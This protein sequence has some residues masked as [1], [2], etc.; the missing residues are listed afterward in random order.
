MSTQAKLKKS[1]EHSKIPLSLK[2]TYTS[3]VPP[4]GFDLATATPAELD[5]YGFPRVNPQGSREF[6]TLRA[7]I[8]RGWTPK[9]RILP[10]LSV[11]KRRGS[12]HRIPDRGGVPNLQSH[13]A[14]CVVTANQRLP[15]PLSPI[16]GHTTDF[17]HEQQVN[18]IGADNH[19][20][21]VFFKDFWKL[22]DLTAF[23]VSTGAPDADPDSALSSY[24]TTNDQ[25]Q[26]VNY[27]SKDGYV[28]ELVFDGT[29]THQ[30]LTV[31]SLEKSTA[32]SG[33]KLVGYQSTINNQQHVIF[34]DENNHIHELV[35]DSS[36]WTD[37][38]LMNSGFPI[39]D[40]KTPL[41]AYYTAWNEQQHII[42]ATL[43]GDVHEL[44]YASGWK[45]HDLM[46]DISPA[47]EA[48]NR[49]TFLDAFGTDFN[50][51]Q[52]INY[53]GADGHIHELF[54]DGSWQAKDLSKEAGALTPFLLPILTS[55]L[56]GYSTEYDDRQH[57]HYI[58]SD[59]HVHEL[60]FDG[61]WQH[62][63]LTK[64]SKCPV[65]ANTASVLNGYATNFNS[66]QHVNFLGTD[67]HLWEIAFAGGNWIST[68]LT[69]FALAPW[70]NVGAIWTVPAAKASLQPSGTEAGGS[71][72]ISSMWVGIDGN[73]DSQDVLQIGT[74]QDVD[75]Q[76]NPYYFAWYEWFAPKRNSDSPAYVDPIVINNVPVAPG[77]EFLASVGYIE[78]NTR[79]RL[80][81]ANISTGDYFTIDLDPPPYAVFNGLFVEWIVEAPGSGEP[82]ETL[83]Q[84][85]TAE[86][87]SAGGMNDEG[88]VA[89]PKNGVKQI[90]QRGDSTLVSVTLASNDV[91]I[92]SLLWDDS[93]ITAAAAAPVADT[94][95][96]LDSYYTPFKEQVHV[97]YLSKD[98]VTGTNH[99]FEIF[100]QNGAVWIVNNLTDL[101]D[102]PPPKDASPLD[103]YSTEFNQQQH[104]NYVADDGNIYE[105]F[106]DGGWN[107]NPIMALA[108][109]AGVVASPDKNTPLCGYSTEFDEQQHV[110]YLASDGSVNALL[111]DGAW[112]PLNVSGAA[113]AKIPAASLTGGLCAVVTDFDNQQHIVFVGA[114]SQVHELSFDGAWHHL[115]LSPAGAPDV[116]SAS[117]L[118]V[119]F[120][121]DNI[122]HVIYIGT[123]Q[124]I[125][126]LFFSGS[127]HHSP[128]SALAS[129]GTVDKFGSLA[130]N[131][132]ATP[133]DGW[134]HVNFIGSDVQFHALQFD[135]TAWT[136]QNLSNLSGNPATPISGTPIVGSAVPLPSPGGQ[137]LYYFDLAGHIHE[138]LG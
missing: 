99:V 96:S 26:H 28:H 16:A 102:A 45:H 35:Y 10:Q 5:H 58:S 12:H 138:L 114:D 36:V 95:F 30:N 83:S 129:A 39:P 49:G 71:G 89:N 55:T 97:N 119:Y 112:K 7:L 126:E 41:A 128:I 48:A 105:L 25:K 136:D 4:P 117:P 133:K 85:G 38:D 115:P 21:E 100:S 113:G 44:V 67:A 11:S 23:A 18:F 8:D 72:W 92:K 37:N 53:I 70:T 110:V 15:K 61:S 81:L 109:G 51:Q 19:I 93:D 111:Y 43:D 101:A 122:Q 127:W 33:S 29:W 130:L 88:E 52:H 84:F 106:Y 104:V 63:D 77:Q 108:A 78:Q 6:S 94:G 59:G 56:A 34:M 123:D 46:I 14:G 124:F 132:G 80:F 9:R 118:A 17:S 120:T 64:L 98:P 24:T 90:I 62:L 121:P 50:Q 60:L 79:G 107:F 68:D 125:H 22:N 3:P 75:I 27:V 13:W 76:G 87:Q 116:D 32:Q 54:H 103:G 47:P 82:Q 31:D 1:T 86:F 134:E 131:A 2:G 20:Y 74:D 57:V 65:N 69:A 137:R 73:N 66:Q 135:G 91:Q 42:Y 40:R